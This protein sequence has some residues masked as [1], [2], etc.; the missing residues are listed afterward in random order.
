MLGGG[1]GVLFSPRSSKPLSVCSDS[2]SS[3]SRSLLL[4]LLLLLQILKRVSNQLISTYK[5]CN[6]VTNWSG[7]LARIVLTNPS[8]GVYNKGNDN[9]SHDLI[10]YRNADVVEPSGRRYRTT[11]T[12][13]LLL[14]M[15]AE[16]LAFVRIATTPYGKTVDREACFFFVSARF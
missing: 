4:L 1:K 7:A 11:E 8:E 2:S 9:I 3:S 14:S 16:N 12:D 5:K 15:I 13:T 10:L 6:P